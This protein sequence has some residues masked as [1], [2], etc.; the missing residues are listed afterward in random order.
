MSSKWG[1]DGIDVSAWYK[2]LVTVQGAIIEQ[3]KEPIRA[4]LFRERVLAARQQYLASLRARRRSRLPLSHPGESRRRGGAARGPAKRAVTISSSRFR[5]PSVL[6]FSDGHRSIEKYATGIRLTYRPTLFLTTPHSKPQPRRLHALTSRAIM[7][8]ARPPVHSPRNWECTLS[9]HSGSELRAERQGLQCVRDRKIQ[10]ADDMAAAKA[11]ACRARPI[12][13]N[14]GRLW[15]HADRNFKQII[16]E[17][18]PGS[19][20]ITSA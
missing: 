17:N 2:E 9:A 6:H 16:E 4:L 14:G 5:S 1:A 18:S 20:D 15:C 8:I 3:V 10:V 12:L 19:D 7:G 13:L 11:A